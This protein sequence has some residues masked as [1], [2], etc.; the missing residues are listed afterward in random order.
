MA[1]FETSY[2]SAKWNLLAEQAKETFDQISTGDATPEDLDRAEALVAQLGGLAAGTVGVMIDMM[3]AA[4]S[5]KAAERAGPSSSDEEMQ[6]LYFDELKRIIESEGTEL[7]V[8]FDEALEEMREAQKQDLADALEE[9]P[10]LTPEQ[11]MLLTH[12]H[13]MLAN[14][15]TTPESPL[16]NCKFGEEEQSILK[17]LDKDSSA[18]M[19]A[20]GSLS[21]SG[22]SG[23]TLEP[24]AGDKF[25]TA[26]EALRNDLGNLR[27]GGNRGDEGPNKDKKEDKKI[28][29]WMNALSN[30]WIGKRFG[31]VKDAAIGMV[32]ALLLLLGKYLATMF[33][34][35][36][37]WKKI[38]DYMSMENIKKYG[39]QFFNYLG[40][41]LRALVGYLKDQLFGDETA[42]E[43]VFSS[44]TDNTR[45]YQSP[46][47]QALQESANSKSWYNFGKT[48]DSINA[49]EAEREHLKNTG[50]DY[51]HRSPWARFILT[52]SGVGLLE[53][54]GLMETAEEFEAR[55]GKK[56]TAN[57]GS[58]GGASAAGGTPTSPPA[59]P[60]VSPSP[61]GDAD[62]SPAEAMS[63][64]GSTTIDSPTNMF[65]PRV[66]NQWGTTTESS[67]DASLSPA[68]TI[69]NNMAP[70]KENAQ[71][72]APMSTGLLSE[73]SPMGFGSTD[74]VLGLMNSKALTG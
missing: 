30:S 19:E 43:S 20:V 3:K 37:I 13:A 16:D 60:S 49:E 44:F 57:G 71:T 24:G 14:E 8:T 38:G 72:Q 36:E 74:S 69:E 62:P 33:S 42:D 70:T 2:E 53:D 52:D 39:L 1:S 47:A 12:I 15:D 10:K 54:L 7:A 73:F 66:N 27:L 40:D 22:L 65:S 23:E 51:D 4:A 35:I 34:D 6:A 58:D 28:K 17:K 59:M 68:V 41:K 45:E 64:P 5:T 21:T 55:T 46:E 32:P 25:T 48:K 61:G 56:S 18:L 67:I 9:A 11:E 63:A 26:I 31:K 29:K 50:Q